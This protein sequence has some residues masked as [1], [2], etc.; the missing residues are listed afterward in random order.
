[1]RR[2]EKVERAVA[3]GQIRRPCRRP[4]RFTQCVFRVD[5]GENG[6]PLLFARIELGYLVCDDPSCTEYSFHY[7]YRGQYALIG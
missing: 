4:G 6:M 1:M 2:N 7:G 3:S 5:H